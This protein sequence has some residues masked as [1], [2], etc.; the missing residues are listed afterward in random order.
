MRV[1]FYHGLEGTPLGDKPTALRQIFTQLEAPDYQGLDTAE[2]I[3]L[4]SEDITSHNEP[5]YL[6]GSS[7]GGLMAAVLADKH[8]DLVMGYLLCAPAL[9]RPEAQ[10]IL[11]VPASAT[12]ILG[13]DDS[14]EHL[15]EAART[16]AKEFDMTTLTVKDGHRLAH[17]VGWIKALAQEGYDAAFCNY[18][19]GELAKVG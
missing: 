19:S 4:A 7:L 16:F 3:R 2:R 8:P 14:T 17:S 9:H 6:I 15:L 13:T 10:G 12:M 11:K 5:V 1:I 18:G